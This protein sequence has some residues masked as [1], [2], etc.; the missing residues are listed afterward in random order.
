MTQP[1]VR[2]YLCHG[3]FCRGESL[4]ATLVKALEQHQLTTTCEIRAS[5]CQSRCDDGPNMTV[6]PGPIRY[7]HLNHH[8]IERI[9]ESHLAHGR[10]VTEFLH[11]SSPPPTDT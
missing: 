1:S 5:G 7:C 2:I 11:P 8:R 3:A 6:W 4:R 10:I 9:V